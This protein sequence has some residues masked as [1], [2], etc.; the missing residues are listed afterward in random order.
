MKDPYKIILYPLR[1]EKGSV[2]QTENKYLFAVDTLSNRIEV[3]QA[4]EEI[5]KVS[6]VNVN[7][8]NILGKRRRV[9]RAEGK[10]PDWKKAIVTLKE[11]ET[12]E[13]K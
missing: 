4:V 5:Y 11:G 10:R 9:R 3:K 13:L 6:V 7:T 12:I 1:T 2:L 8:M